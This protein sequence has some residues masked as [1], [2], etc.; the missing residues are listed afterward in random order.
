MAGYVAF[1]R[2]IGPLNPNM[3]NANLRRVFGDLGFRSAQTVISSGNVVFDSDTSD[4]QTLQSQLEEAWP[5]RL[6]FA[7]TTIIWSAD[8]LRRLVEA[9]PFEGLVHGPESYLLV[10]FCQ[11]PPTEQAPLP[12]PPATGVYRLVGLVEGTLCTVTDT[13]A[14]KSPDV[15]AWMER[16]YGR[17]ISSRTWKTVLRILA[18]MD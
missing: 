3:R 6:G 16:H 2:G 7:S 1:L 18:K 4:I 12:E 13:T 11:E 15:M 10:T 5:T 9:D 17:R 14:T 8:Q